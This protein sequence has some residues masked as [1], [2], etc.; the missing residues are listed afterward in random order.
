MPKL[1]NERTENLTPGQLE[2][3]LK[4]IEEEIHPQAGP[5]MLMALYTGMRRSELFRLKWKDVD[6]EW[7]FIHIR[8]PKGGMDQTIPLNDRA[9]RVL[10]S[11][12]RTESSYVFPG[13]EGGLRTDIHHQ[14]NRIPE[15]LKKD[16]IIH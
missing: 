12:T 16:N 11:V 8:G 5:V 4:A 2:N 6:V 7:R 1:N 14:V 10:D 3:F 15:V 13:T 9:Q